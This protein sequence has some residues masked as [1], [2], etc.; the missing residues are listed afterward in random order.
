MDNEL[1]ASYFRSVTELDTD[2]NKKP[3]F[4]LFTELSICKTKVLLYF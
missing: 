3:L 2:H 1:T 4:N